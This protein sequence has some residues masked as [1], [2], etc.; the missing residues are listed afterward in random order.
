MRRRWSSSKRGPKS[1]VRIND[2]GFG[3]TTRTSLL[4]VGSEALSSTYHPGSASTGM[5]RT[6][7]PVAP[8]RKSASQRA[9]CRAACS[10]GLLSTH[11]G[12][13][14]RAPPR[15]AAREFSLDYAA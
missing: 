10:N 14:A 6:G 5:T 12:L 11:L 15:A 9:A 4:D 1:T 3:L 8:V 7:L 13:P 2:A